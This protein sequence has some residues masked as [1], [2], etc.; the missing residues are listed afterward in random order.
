MHSHTKG[1]WVSSGRGQPVPRTPR[2]WALGAEPSA[3]SP[4]RRALGA[5]PPAQSPWR[6]CACAAG[7]GRGIVRISASKGSGNTVSPPPSPYADGSSRP[8]TVRKTVAATA[9]AGGRF[10]STFGSAAFV[11]SIW[12]TDST[13]VFA[14]SAST[15]NKR[16]VMS[17]ALHWIAR[18]WPTERHLRAAM[19]QA[20]YAMA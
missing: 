9:R 10:G 12:L 4:R 6:V 18:S 13:R 20:L 16:A 11:P 3:Q 15:S 7:G 5:K 17:A 1:W 8:T 2:R 14:V 19:M